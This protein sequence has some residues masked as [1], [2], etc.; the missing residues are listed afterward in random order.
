MPSLFIVISVSNS[1]NSSTSSTSGSRDEDMYSNLP[2]DKVVQY[3][4]IL[5]E[6]NRKYMGQN[7]KP[8]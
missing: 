8:S 2:P 5:D 3:S 6:I 1:E 7:F 4:I